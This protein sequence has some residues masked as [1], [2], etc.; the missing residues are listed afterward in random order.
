VLAFPLS[1]KQKEASRFVMD[2]VEKRQSGFLHA[3]CGAGKTEI[4]YETLLQ[5]MISEMRICMAIPRKDIV[6]ELAK[7]LK[8]VF[9]NSVIKPLYEQEKDDADADIVVSTIHQL[10]RYDQEFDWIVLDEADAFPY[11]D[12]PFLHRL[13]EKALKKNGILFQMSATKNQETERSLQSDHTKTFLI[14]ARF[15][16]QPLDRPEWIPVNQLA[17]EITKTQK[18]P[19]II[20]EWLDARIK[21]EK[22]AILFVPSIRYGEMLSALLNQFGYLTE[23]ISSLSENGAE[24]IARF[25]QGGLRFLVSTTILERGV[26]FKNIDCAVFSAEKAVFDV[27]TLVQ[28]SGR[29]GR[30]PEHP[31]GRISYFCEEKTVAMRKAS[32]YIE[33][34]NRQG[35]KE[36]LLTDDL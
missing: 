12:D 35:K 19:A 15:H 16:K 33:Q 6:I 31:H 25:R 36:G 28:I 10:I 17:T 29:V 5:A 27:D 3:V 1:E 26:T 30:D 21:E 13:V 8:G 20:K 7:R 23:N 11:R 24:V 9:P 4:L 22:Q 34:M 32:L 18:I 2:C 14:P